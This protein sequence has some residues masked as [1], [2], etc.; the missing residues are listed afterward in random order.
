VRHQCATNYSN[1]VIIQKAATPAP[2]YK[3]VVLPRRFH[4]HRPQLFPSLSGP[5]CS[6]PCIGCPC[7]MQPPRLF[8]RANQE[9]PLT[10]SSPATIHPTYANANH[11]FHPGPSTPF[12]HPLVAIFSI[13]GLSSIRQEVSPRPK[14]SR[15]FQS[16]RNTLCV[17][18][19]TLPIKLVRTLSC[20]WINEKTPQLCRPC[21]TH[22]RSPL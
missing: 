11:R 4:H 14:S 3:A 10:P 2:R 17:Y 15:S 13:A 18:G 8:R 22:R 20:D 9:N 21:Q 7:A 12:S 1:H 6:F 5:P 19:A 16:R